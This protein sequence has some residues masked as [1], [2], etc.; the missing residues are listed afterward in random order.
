MCRSKKKARVV[1]NTKKGAKGN[2][3]RIRYCLV[4]ATN[5]IPSAAPAQK[6]NTAAESRREGPSS[7]PRPTASLASPN[8]IQ[9]PRDAN[10]SK[11]KGAASRK[12]DPNC[13]RDGKCG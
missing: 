13:Q 8:P 10:Q 11:A 4:S 7:Q 3:L 5:R 1:P 9:R 12:P 6:D 2:S